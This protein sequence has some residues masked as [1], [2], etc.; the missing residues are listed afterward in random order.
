MISATF[1]FKQR[2]SDEEFLRLDTAIE[3]F[4]IAHPEYKG[5]DVWEN[6]EKSLSAVV[7]Y[8]STRAGLE[9]LR[10]FSLHQE[11]KSQYKNWYAGFHVIISEVQASYGDDWVDHPT[12]GI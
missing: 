2:S 10:S 4:V 8:F 5:K 3:E 9:A 7:Y 6:S 12:K 1:I 11:A